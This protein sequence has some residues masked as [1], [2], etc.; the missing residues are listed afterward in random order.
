[1][2]DLRVLLF[3][4][5]TESFLMAAT[6]LRLFGQNSGLKILM[7]IGVIHGL[8]VWLIRGAYLYYHIPF[9]THTLI[10]TVILFLLIRMLAR[11]SWGEALGATLTSVS[12]VI[13]GSSI[14]GIIVQFYH[15]NVQDIMNNTWLHVLIGHTENVF[16]VLLLVINSVF[17]FTITKPLEIR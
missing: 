15:L 3:L 11:V 16:L 8:A 9:G 13:I 6:G 7:A 12:L 4:H 5:I 17:G 10:L 2:E 1:M 14:S